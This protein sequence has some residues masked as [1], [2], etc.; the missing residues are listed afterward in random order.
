MWDIR[1]V[2]RENHSGKNEVVSMT[3]VGSEYNNTEVSIRWDGCINL[4]SYYN[5]YSPDDE[6]SKEKGENCHYIHMCDIDDMINK[7]TELKKIAK[8][9]FSEKYYKE[10]WD[11]NDENSL[12]KE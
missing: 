7:L 9:N 2:Y 11:N 5:G 10:F 6:D 12:S 1:K 4:W 3:L 8:E